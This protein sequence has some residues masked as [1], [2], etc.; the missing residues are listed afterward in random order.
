MI[1]FGT[2]QRLPDSPALMAAV[3]ALPERMHFPAMRER[4]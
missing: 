3:A 2:L 1:P 4:K